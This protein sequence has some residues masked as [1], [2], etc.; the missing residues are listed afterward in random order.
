MLTD[1]EIEALRQL[2]S[3]QVLTMSGISEEGNLTTS[4][5]RETITV[6]PFSDKIEIVVSPDLIED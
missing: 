4:V 5:D 3:L 2:I 1:K 6:I